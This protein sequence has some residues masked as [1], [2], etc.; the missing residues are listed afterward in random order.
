[1]KYELISSRFD[2]TG[3]PFAVMASGQVFTYD[4]RWRPWSGRDRLEWLAHARNY[5]Q[6]RTTTRRSVAMAAIAQITGD[7]R[8]ADQARWINR[9]H[10]YYAVDGEVVRAHVADK[11]VVYERFTDQGWVSADRPAGDLTE[12]E[13][14]AAEEFKATRGVEEPEPLHPEVA[15][16]KADPTAV[17]RAYVVTENGRDQPVARILSPGWNG[18]AELVFTSCGPDDAWRPSDLLGQIAAGRYDWTAREVDEAQSDAAHSAM[19]AAIEWADLSRWI[20]HRVRY[21]FLVMDPTRKTHPHGLFRL[22]RSG[23][24]MDEESFRDGR[25][26][27]SFRMEDIR[28]CSSTFEC[29]EVTEA[30]ARRYQDGW[31][32]WS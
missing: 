30:D 7:V 13:P 14:Q 6:A 19:R 3:T 22:P 5:C 9:V 11:T 20:H 31:Y 4:L 16:R 28:R 8:A 29:I 10:R 25:W 24:L 17:R 18:N 27:P 23:G 12:V 21:Y 15:R 1:M 32:R 26:E 2:R